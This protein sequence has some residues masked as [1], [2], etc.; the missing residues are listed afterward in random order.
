MEHKDWDLMKVGKK[1]DK[2]IFKASFKTLAFPR[3]IKYSINPFDT[4]K[5]STLFDRIF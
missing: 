5:E 2:G 3:M 4:H 1:S